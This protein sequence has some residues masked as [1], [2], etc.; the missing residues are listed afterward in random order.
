[1]KI[2]KIVVLSSL[3]AL[4]LSAVAA[5]DNRLEA[6]YV[7]G[8]SLA[9]EP[10]RI[11]MEVG[12]LL[13][14]DN[15]EFEVHSGNFQAV[16]NHKFTGV[17]RIINYRFFGKV[18][19]ESFLREEFRVMETVYT[20]NHPS[21]S[22][23]IKFNRAAD[24]MAI[25]GLNGRRLPEDFLQVLEQDIRVNETLVATFRLTICPAKKQLDVELLTTDKLITANQYFLPV[26]N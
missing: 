19:A 16:R 7:F 1:M 10:V 24:I 8:V 11:E 6:K 22:V 3:L 4:S 21:K 17:A 9:G 23:A 26:F 18:P 12:E 5:S 15:Q 25:G 20:F 13:V 2:P 14:Y